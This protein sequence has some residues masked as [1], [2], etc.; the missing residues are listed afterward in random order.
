MYYKI[1]TAEELKGTSYYVSDFID[2]EPH[3]DVWDENWDVMML[4]Q[5]YSTQWR[6]AMG[7]AYALDMNIFQHEL[8][9]KK[10]SED[11]FDM[12]IAKLGI[13]EAEALKWLH[14]N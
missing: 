6:A 5:K 11:V 1:P 13:I 7:G 4:F 3:V 9:R 14:R 10:V 8:M 12:T 2:N